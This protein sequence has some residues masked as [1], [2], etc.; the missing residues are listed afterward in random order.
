MTFC[1]RIWLDATKHCLNRKRSFATLFFATIFF[2]NGFAADID[3]VTVP[4]TLWIHQPT[5]LQV[6]E[7]AELNAQKKVVSQFYWASPGMPKFRKLESLKGSSKSSPSGEVHRF[8]VKHMFSGGEWSFFNFNVVNYADPLKRTA[9]EDHLNVKFGESVTFSL[10]RV[11]NEMLT[12][13]L[14]SEYTHHDEKI[15]HERPF[16]AEVFA[17]EENGTLLVLE[18][19]LGV[20]GATRA[21]K[22]LILDSTNG[23]TQELGVLDTQI[24]SEKELIIYFLDNGARF[25][26]SED[27][28]VGSRLVDHSSHVDVRW[29][30]SLD[31]SAAE[32]ELLSAGLNLHERYPKISNP[33]ACEFLLK[34]SQ[35]QIR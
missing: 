33:S 13:V 12:R 26:F 32:V 19:L 27:E 29:S 1:F 17:D 28:K 2:N 21:S 7:A 24:D 8:F 6:M 16:V 4:K 3:S 25:E 31:K 15:S 10:N 22:V 9:L 35:G 11:P 30:R 5:K 23:L 34:L 20:D 18:K 14:I